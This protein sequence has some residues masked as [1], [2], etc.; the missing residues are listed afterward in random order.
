MSN[1]SEHI[2]ELIGALSKAKSEFPRITKNIDVDYKTKSGH[3]IKYSYAD[4]ESIISETQPILSK[5]EISVVQLTHSDDMFL[6]LETILCHTSGQWISS[7]IKF[8]I[9]KGGQNPLQDCGI[10]MTYLRR[11]SYTNV[12]CISPCEDT[13][14]TGA[15]V[16]IKDIPKKEME[17]RAKEIAEVIVPK[18]DEK[19]RHK[20][21]YKR[22]LDLGEEVIEK[23]RQYVEASDKEKFYDLDD[24]DLDV[25]ETMF[26]SKDK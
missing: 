4:L 26:L 21:I 8:P 10:V 19:A 2:G 9:P 1:K 14:G 12:L 5:Y 15:D 25:I 24:E 16:N 22:L 3:H 17:Y 11:Y 23:T 18:K 6:I 7:T 20:Q 13:D